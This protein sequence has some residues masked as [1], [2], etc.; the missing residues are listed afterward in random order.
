[1]SQ[2]TNKLLAALPARDYARIRPL[3]RNVTLPAEA[4][5]PHCGQTRVYFPATGLCSIINSMA[6]GSAIEVACVG[7]E[8][9]VGLD[10]L[11]LQCPKGRNSFVQVGDGTTQY[12]PLVL[13]EHE[14]ARKG[15]FAA[16]VDGY[17]HMFLQMVIHSIAC[18]RLHSF[19][20]RCCRWLLSAHARLGRARFE[21][22]PRF[23]ARA[24]GG[25]NSEVAAVLKSLDD[26]SIIRH[27]AL[28]VTIV[29][30]VGLR[31][32]ACRCH[33][34][35]GFINARRFT[36]AEDPKPVGHRNGGARILPMRPGVGACTLCGLSTN[37]PHKNA[38]D[39]ILALDEEIAAST[40]RTH[41]L[42]KYRAQMLASRAQMF[43]DI[44]KRSRSS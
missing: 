32:L 21:L 44:L 10:S 38:H 9:I 5:L 31:R 12:M 19:E 23:L 42:R 41:T 35:H 36:A 33:E 40:R 37:A 6:D 39:C 20:E 2:S 14:M 29:D 22:K 11:T 7:N 18:N 8:G 15:E 13:F 16:I 30:S 28:S 34:T 26:M 25:K 3:L 17:C 27:D 24:M 4:A 1:V 43:R